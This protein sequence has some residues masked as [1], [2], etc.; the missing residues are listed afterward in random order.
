MQTFVHNFHCNSPKHCKDPTVTI[1][2][3][4]LRRVILIYKTALPTLKEPVLVN[5]KGMI[6]VFLKIVIYVTGKGH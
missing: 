6:D 1:S 5:N 3:L 4:V 2:N